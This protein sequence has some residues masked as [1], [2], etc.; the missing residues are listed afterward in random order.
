M[1]E[2][3]RRGRDYERAQE[4]L[5]VIAMCLILFLMIVP[6][7]YEYVKTYQTVYLKMYPLLYVNYTSTE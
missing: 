3:R 2:G 1:G 6:W 7:T 5:G 4:T